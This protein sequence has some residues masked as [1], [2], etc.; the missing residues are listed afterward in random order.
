MKCKVE[1]KNLEISAV[2]IKSDEKMK[3]TPSDFNLMESMNLIKHT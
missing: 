3:K 1:W 2:C